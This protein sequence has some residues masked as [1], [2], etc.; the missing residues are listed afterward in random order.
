VA[1]LDA[2][3]RAG[4]YPESVNLAPTPVQRRIGPG[5]FELG[6]AAFEV[7]NSPGHAAGHLSFT[8]RHNAAT[9]LF[10][11]A[12]VFARGRVV[13][14]ATPDTDVPVLAKSVE[15]LAS[16]RPDALFPGHC[17]YVLARAASHL[18][19]AWA[20]FSTGSLPASLD[21]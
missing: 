7:L 4:T 21:S 11:G 10:T 17:E 18:D 16:I 1:G 8:V 20:A 5:Q 12:T 13:V 9:A 19:A 14:L 15:T 3:K 6:E 2:A